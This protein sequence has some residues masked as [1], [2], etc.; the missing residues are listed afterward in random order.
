MLSSMES[1]ADEAGCW[2]HSWGVAMAV[3]AAVVVLGFYVG[4]VILGR[5]VGK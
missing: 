2:Q 4:C 5:M 3:A 1:P